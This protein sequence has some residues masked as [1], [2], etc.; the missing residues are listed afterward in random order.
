[1]GISIIVDDEMVVVDGKPRKVPG[2][3]DL[4][5]AGVHAIQVDNKNKV[6]IEWVERD[7]SKRSKIKL[8][9]TD[10]K[11][12]TDAW[13][14]NAPKPAA[15]IDPNAITMAEKINLLWAERET[16]NRDPINA[17][18]EKTKQPSKKGRTG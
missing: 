2:L 6:D 14:A 18:I 11:P 15:P 16:G 13:K 8:K 3:A 5:P 1:M 9:K 7:R 12:V 4:V 10:L 17:V